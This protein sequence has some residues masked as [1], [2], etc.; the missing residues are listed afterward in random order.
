MTDNPI[1]KIEDETMWKDTGRQAYLIMQGAMEEGA[2]LKEAV[3]VMTAFYAG[4]FKGVM[5][6]TDDGEG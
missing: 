4:L 6:E 5:P 2:S 3:T 1:N